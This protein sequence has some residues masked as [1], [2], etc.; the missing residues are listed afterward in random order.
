MVRSTKSAETWQAL[1]ELRCRREV[2]ERWLASPLLPDD[3]Q[4]SLR[5]MLREV[6][7][8]LETQTKS[9]TQN[10]GSD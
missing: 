2:I 9:A 5:S 1:I 7:D 6:D 4:Q 10:T 3:L 8:Q